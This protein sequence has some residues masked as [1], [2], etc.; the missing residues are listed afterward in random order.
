MAGGA[1]PEACVSVAPN[2]I[3][4]KDIGASASARVKMHF[5]GRLEAPAAPGRPQ[6]M[7]D[8]KSTRLNSS[9]TV[10]SYAVFCLKKKKRKKYTTS[11]AS[12]MRTLY[13]LIYS[14]YYLCRIITSS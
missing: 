5:D 1:A 13:I 9:H 7:G 2:F 12:A 10:I 14:L 11:T 3:E 4:W 6:A 8:R